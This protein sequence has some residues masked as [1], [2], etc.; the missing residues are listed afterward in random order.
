MK[1]VGL[2]PRLTGLSPVPRTPSGRR[3]HHGSRSDTCGRVGLG[4][5][6]VRYR[7]DGRD[8]SARP[9]N[10]ASAD[11][12]RRRRGRQHRVVGDGVAA[13]ALNLDVPLG[14]IRLGLDYGSAPAPPCSLYLWLTWMAPAV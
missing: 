10:D 2:L 7:C 6:Y 11:Q 13:Q 4:S 14:V 8:K 5:P 9:E 12:A 1:S 3:T